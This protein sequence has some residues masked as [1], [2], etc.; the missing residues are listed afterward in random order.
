M[1]LVFSDWRVCIA[2][3][4]GTALVLAAYRGH[5]FLL[6]V[7]RGKIETRKGKAEPKARSRQRRCR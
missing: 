1:Q 7:L 5:V 4:G 2:V 3:L 6:D